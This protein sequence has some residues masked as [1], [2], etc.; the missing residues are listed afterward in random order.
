MSDNAPWITFYEDML[1][2]FPPTQQHAPGPAPAV[3]DA[4]AAASTVTGLDY[5]GHTTLIAG[6]APVADPAPPPPDP[7]PVVPT[8]EPPPPPPAS[9]PPTEP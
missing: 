6:E 2:A 7:A 3:A 1:A 9:P 8:P 4:P 5:L